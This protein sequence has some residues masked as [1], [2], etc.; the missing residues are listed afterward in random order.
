ML[1]KSR[2]G[3]FNYFNNSLEITIFCISEVPS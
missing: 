3:K 2:N 1:T